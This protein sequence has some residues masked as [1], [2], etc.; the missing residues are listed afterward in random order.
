M[1][2]KAYIHQNTPELFDEFMEKIDGPNLDHESDHELLKW[3]S[4]HKDQRGYV[5]EFQMNGVL[6]HA[7]AGEE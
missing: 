5:A 3:F 4:C 6:V 2:I 1:S 7:F